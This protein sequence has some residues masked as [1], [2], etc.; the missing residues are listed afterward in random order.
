MIVTALSVI[1]VVGPGFDPRG[2]ESYASFNMAIVVLAIVLAPKIGPMIGAT[3]Q[4]WMLF[5]G[6]VSYPLYLSHI[7]TLFICYLL[8]PKYLPTHQW[9]YFI[10]A[11]AV[12]ILFTTLIDLPIRR[13]RRARR[14]AR[15]PLELAPAESQ[16]R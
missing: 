1:A 12:G 11:L 13:R 16:L 3:A 4:R 5:A 9:F 2:P 6:D 8:W 10:A 7:S 15:I 14:T